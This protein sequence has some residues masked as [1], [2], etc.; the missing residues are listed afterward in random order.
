MHKNS[1]HRMVGTF[2]VSNCS[3]VQVDVPR[4]EPL[5]RYNHFSSI[6]I[7]SIQAR[8]ALGLLVFSIFPLL[9]L[10]SSGD[11][12][13]SFQDCLVDCYPSQCPQSLPLSLRITLWTCE[14]DCAYRCSHVVTSAAEARIFAQ[15][16]A[17]T[18]R[19]QQFYGKWAFWRFF[20]IQEPASALFSLLNLRAHVKGWSLLKRRVPQTH[21]MRP[22]YIAWSFIS[23]N[24]WIWSAV[25]HTRGECVCATL[26]RTA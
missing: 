25:F 13:K 21:P 17:T 1:G 14:D 26:R 24:A 18:V 23:M 9:L 3:C 5:G 16:G 10:A 20:G 7:Y 22:Y 6:Y 15:K 8:R 2:R 11:R 4:C 19:I 12:S